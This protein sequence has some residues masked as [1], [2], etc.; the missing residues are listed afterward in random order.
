MSDDT[1]GDED[2]LINCKIS[3][4]I[5]SRFVRSCPIVDFSNI[6]SLTFP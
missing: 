2:I 5:I 4:E 1:C 6:E 3:D